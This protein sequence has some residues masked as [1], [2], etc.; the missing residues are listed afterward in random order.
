MKPEH[1]TVCQHQ[2]RERLSTLCKQLGTIAREKR[3]ISSDLKDQESPGPACYNKHDPHITDR[4][5]TAH[6]S[7][8]M[9]QQLFNRA[10]KDTMKIQVYDKSYERSFKNSLGP[11]PAAYGKM[12]RVNSTDRFKETA[13][14]RSKRKLTQPDIGPSPADY[15]THI[16]KDKQ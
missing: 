13:F 7:H 1:A 10:R 15:D 2:T 11:G 16:S 14:T 3:E 5:L 4:P 8:N 6:K 12:Y 9:A